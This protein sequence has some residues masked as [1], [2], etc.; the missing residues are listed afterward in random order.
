LSSGGP[1]KISSK[2]KKYALH[3]GADLVGIASA[4]KLN[5][6]AP[7]GH[8]PSDFLPNAKSVVVMAV[9]LIDGV[10]E[11]LPESWREFNCNYFESTD[12]ANSLAFKVARFLENQGYRAY[13]VSY[14][15]RYGIESEGFSSR[16]AAVEAGLGEIGL[17]NLLITPRY[18]PRIRLI[19]VMTDAE[20]APD[21]RFGGK[22]CDG[23][24]CGYRCVSI[25]PAKALSV[26]GRIDY[27]KCID[28]NR[29]FPALRT[30]DSRRCGMCMAA[31]PRPEP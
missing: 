20:L 31:C 28:Y 26:D 3:E 2:L 21:K 10:I 17:N 25:C 19:A 27:K 30:G 8:R 7:E 23:K 5:R 22:I 16:H 4:D 24:R 18:G 29:S 1:R 9:H 13:P 6:I 11:R 12:L 14:G 15:S